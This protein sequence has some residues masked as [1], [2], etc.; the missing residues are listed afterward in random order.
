MIVNSYRNLKRQ[1]HD[2]INKRGNFI[3][4]NIDELHLNIKNDNWIENMFHKYSK[5]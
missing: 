5:Q 2:D 1:K 3:H 4:K